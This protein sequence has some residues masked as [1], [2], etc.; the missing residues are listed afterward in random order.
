LPTIEEFLTGR[1]FDLETFAQAGKLARAALK[2]ISDV[3]GSSAYREQ[4][5]ENLFL[6]LYHD[7]A[8]GIL[9]YS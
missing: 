9:C 3:R 4:L 7:L 6:K 8:G 5:I 1:E 2:P